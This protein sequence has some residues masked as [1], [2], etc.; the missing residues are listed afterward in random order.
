MILISGATGNVGKVLVKQLLDEDVQIRV[1]V[2]DERKV[3]EFGNRADVVVGDLDKPDTLRTAMRGVDRLYFVTPVTEQVVN[4]LK[5]AKQAGAKYVVKQST[6]EADRSLGPGKWHREQEELVKSMGFAWTFIRPT[7]FM[8]NVIEWW[9]ATIK[10]QNAVY[11][12]GGNGTVPPVDARDVAAVACT[13]LTRP[14]HEGKIYEV[15]GPQAL[16]IGEMVQILSKAL[17]KPLRYVNVPAILAAIW[18]RRFGM[19][20]EL[21]KGLME[22]LGALRRNEY[23]YVTDAVE[24]IG[25][26]KP[27]TFDTWCRENVNAFRA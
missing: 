2:R 5:A 14:G 3:A 10:M 1:L 26:V 6:I 25:G 21:V 12:P 13:V 18:L 4:L 15:T 20:R 22:T 11:F 17:G 8:S 9:G 27:Q 23:A 19:S 7:M 16:K 24:C